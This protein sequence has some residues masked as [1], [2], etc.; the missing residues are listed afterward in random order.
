MLAG[1]ESG[2]SQGPRPRWDSDPD[3]LSRSNP[4]SVL[5][6]DAISYSLGQSRNS[7]TSST[8]FGGVFR[9]F[10]TIPEH[11]CVACDCARKPIWL[12]ATWVPVYSQHLQPDDDMG[13]LE[14]PMLPWVSDLSHNRP[15]LLGAC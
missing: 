6:H 5:P 10:Q 15:M 1:I 2:H 7:L 9:G 12:T 8:Q 11:A 13:G 4:R 3:A 14:P